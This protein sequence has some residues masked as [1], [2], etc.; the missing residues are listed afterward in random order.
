MQ[1]SIF[2]SLK[3]Q[4]Q[5]NQVICDNVLPPVRKCGVGSKLPAPHGL[6][7]CVQ[8]GVAWGN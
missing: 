2:S 6:Q 1:G 7:M 5:Y 8:V 3:P 4:T